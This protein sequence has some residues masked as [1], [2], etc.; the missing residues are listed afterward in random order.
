MKALN[1]VQGPPAVAWPDATH[2]WSK[3]GW[4][5]S[6]RVVCRDPRPVTPDQT[7]PWTATTTDPTRA[8]R[9]FLLTLRPAPSRQV[10]FWL[11]PAPCQPSSRTGS[12]EGGILCGNDWRTGFRQA[13]VTPALA[14]FVL[15]NSPVVDPFLIAISRFGRQALPA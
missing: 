1:Q 2:T 11:C 10:C 3:P 7:C 9:A 14:R 5:S 15:T 13:A 6:T 4:F 8:A 12:P